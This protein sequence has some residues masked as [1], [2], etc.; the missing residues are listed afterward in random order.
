MRRYDWSAIRRYYEAGHTLREAQAAFGFSNGAWASAV[1][2]GDVT[3]RPGRPPGRNGETAQKVRDLL[4]AGESK[5]DIARRLGIT[6]SSVSRHAARAGFASDERAARRYDWAAVQAYYDEGHSVGECQAR[7]GFSACSFTAAQRRGDIVA[8]P[9]SAPFDVVFAANT[10]R[11]RVHLKERLRQADLLP[12]ACEECGL[13]EWRGELLSLQLH[14]VNGN[15]D[16]NR[17][18]NLRLLCPNCHAQTP[19]WGGRN[20]RRAAA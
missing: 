11:S 14:H 4:R 9:R 19:N 1:E 10:K 18:E 16:D 7:F 20:A 15:P 13:A 3:P 12:Q 6:K 2:R 8:R 17:V 5:A